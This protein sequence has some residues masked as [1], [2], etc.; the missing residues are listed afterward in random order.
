[1]NQPLP[2]LPDQP[3]AE[4]A[5]EPTPARAEPVLLPD[6]RTAMA[7]LAWEIVRGVTPPRF[8]APRI[9][10]RHGSRQSEL[11]GQEG[12]VGA[13]ALLL[14]MANGVVC[15]SEEAEELKKGVWLLVAAFAGEGPVTYWL[16]LTEIN[17]ETD[18][19]EFRPVPGTE[20][21]HSTQNAFA[22]AI[23]ATAAVTALEG[24]AVA[25]LRPASQEDLAETVST[26]LKPDDRTADLP[27]RRVRPL[28]LDHPV[29]VLRNPPPVRK[30]GIALGGL[31]ALGAGVL[32][33]SPLITAALQPAPEPA[34]E[35][36][37]VQV[38]RGAF[39][40]ACVQGLDAWW[41]RIA[42]WQ[43]ASGGCAL[44]GQLPR[45]LGLP[46]SLP[47]SDATVP[48]IV[49]QSYAREITANPV[50]A[51]RAASRMIEDWPYGGRSGA[52]ELVVWQELPLRRVRVGQDSAQPEADT[53][54]ARIDE[55]W[56]DTPGAVAVQG[57]GG[58]EIKAPGTPSEILRRANRVEGLEPARL[59][60]SETGP[61]VLH[62]QRPSVR[63][64]PIDLLA[65]PPPSE[66][67]PEG[68]A[69]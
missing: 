12:A 68:S 45:D 62:L 35:V 52:G 25:D 1:M 11:D 4:D 17:A 67:S 16:G 57:R 19:P 58:F 27:I 54:R 50:L 47:R 33:I 53:I 31:G 22:H 60:V 39:A 40:T 36:V 21:L 48:L 63:G 32:L 7:G 3:E 28:A 8:D 6:G 46:R 38:D 65:A 41:P 69:P 14:A 43:P 13:G 56:A 18:P 2:H 55:L 15:A 61:M 24:I 49:W 23:S 59:V 10:L 30:I 37:R 5:P 26:T 66:P 34:P 42:G 51:D 64:V 44:E 20:E 29:F 9:V